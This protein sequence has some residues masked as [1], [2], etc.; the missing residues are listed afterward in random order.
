MAW[1]WGWGVQLEPLVHSREP[2]AENA[3]CSPPGIE[4]IGKSTV[5]KVRTFNLFSCGQ[6]T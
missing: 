1:G 6:V 5:K 4:Y 2:P 3:L